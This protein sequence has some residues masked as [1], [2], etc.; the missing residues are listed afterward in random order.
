MLAEADAQKELPPGST[1]ATLME[2]L[3]GQISAEAREEVEADRRAAAG[4]KASR[5]PSFLCAPRWNA[6]FACAHGRAHAA[7][8]ADALARPVRTQSHAHDVAFAR[9]EAGLAP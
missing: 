1:F 3:L 4:E 7:R 6:G 5:M 9:K 8:H 2:K